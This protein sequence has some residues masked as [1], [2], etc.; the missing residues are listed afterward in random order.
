[1]FTSRFALFRGLGCVLAFIFY[2]LPGFAQQPGVPT[3]PYTVVY[4]LKPGYSEAASVRAMD[5]S[6]LQESFEKIKARKVQQVFPNQAAGTRSLRKQ[7]NQV[8]LSLLYKLTYGQDQNFEQVKRA[9]LSTGMVDYVE[10]VYVREPMHQP[11]DPSSDSL[12]TAQY[13]LKLINAYRGWAITKGSEEVVIGILDTGFRLSHKELESK[14]ALNSS[15]PIDGIDNDNDGL[16]DNYK[17]WDFS[18]NDNNV[19]DDTSWK[20]HGTAV[21]G[22]TSASSDN[23]FGM[24]AVGFNTKF[25]PLKVFPSTANGN[26]G[27]YEAMVYAAEK[28][29]KVINLSW[30]GLG[31]S[32]FEQ[33]IINYVALDKNVVIVASAGNTGTEVDYYPATYDN[34]LSVAGTDINDR[35]NYTYNYGVDV[36]APGVNMYS[37][38]GNTEEGFSRFWGTSF[39]APVVAGAVALIRTQFPALNSRQVVER[40]RMSADDIYA[41]N[42][43]PNFAGKL[44]RG[45]LNLKKALLATDLKSARATALYFES[46]ATPR[47]GAIVPLTADITNFLSPLSNLQ[48]RLTSQSEFLAVEQATVTAGSIATMRSFTTTPDKTFK[49][50][51]SESTPLNTKVIVRLDY[52]DGAYTDFQYITLILNPSFVTLD[53]NNLLVTINSMG[54][55]GYDGL[56]LDKGL[57][58]RY[59]GNSLLFEGGLMVAT[60]PTKVADNIRNEYY[61]SDGDFTPVSNARLHHQTP[62]A[63][64]EGRAVMQDEANTGLQIKHITYA[65]ADQSDQDYVI[66]EYHLKNTTNATIENAYAGIFADWDI[67]NSSDGF[68]YNAADWDNDLRM[69]YVYSLRQPLPFTG[70][71]LLTNGTA[72]YHAIDNYGGDKNS[73]SVEDGFTTQ[74]KYKA[75]T[76]GVARQ[77]AGSGKGNNVSHVVSSQVQSIAPGQTTIVAFA[78]LAGDDLVALKQHATAAQQKYKLLKTGP[79]PLAIQETLCKGSTYTWKPE[80]GSKY[81]FYT[82]AEKSNLLSSGAS[83]TLKNL[84]ENT[85]IYAANIDSVFESAVA[86]GTFALAQTPEAEIN[87]TGA[88]VHAGIP[89]TFTSQTQH[90]HNLTWYLPETEPRTSES[91]TYTFT[92]AGTYEISL[93][94]TDEQNCTTVTAT[95]KVTV[96]P[97]LPGPAPLALTETMCAGNSLVWAPEGG[98]TFNFYADSEKKNLIGTGA[99]FALTNI[100][101]STTIYATNADSLVESALSPAVIKLV[102]KPEIDFTFDVAKIYPGMPV[103]FVSQSTNAATLRWN[104]GTPDTHTS[105]STVHTFA[106]PG[107]YSVTLTATDNLNCNTV[108]VIKQV[109]V[110][111]TSPA[112]IAETLVLYPNPSNAI[113]TVNLLTDGDAT[114]LPKISIWDAT[115]RAVQPPVTS[116]KAQQVTI[117]VSNLQAGLYFVR[118]DY[119][120]TSIT[121]RILVTN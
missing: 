44:G 82:D 68:L 59:K 20:T 95:K 12:V 11:N 24:A 94:A 36:S 13:Y 14:V 7:K 60:A 119:S 1:M 66:L 79:A 107:T 2:T 29:C 47:A 80:G 103:T 55:L 117:N 21:A 69:G 104:F 109:E 65:W 110:Q 75:L 56:N 19:F 108:N 77:K 8:D 43:A 49:V 116:P 33:D 15:D 23:G 88:K 50:R 61:E 5:G 64:Q 114:K 40:I 31:Y 41:K 97:L 121:R 22:I 73:F 105:S 100:T 35:N 26:F 52:T 89:V 3:Q 115:G 25:L 37:V 16:I 42:A 67:S 120:N 4:K 39:A 10:P 53:A 99:S 81:N 111:A 86:A 98:T 63:T 45:R 83:Y 38:N 9:L 87:Q 102:P 46:K 51:I 113:V 34:V 18:D 84:T 90:A 54:N 28:G 76:S 92:K 48:I 85:V 78:L 30:G 106:A 112:A 32:Q 118:F 58:I 74:E 6:R 72:G 62:L 91:I 57:G 70:I 96:L 71:K 17:G 27:G 101:K 93:T